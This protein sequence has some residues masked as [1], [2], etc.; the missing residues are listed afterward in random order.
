MSIT[1]RDFL[2]GILAASMA[3][4]IVRAESLM[5]L[6]VPN[7]KII[8]YADDFVSTPG[9]AKYGSSDYLK[10]DETM[11][12]GFGDGDFTVETWIR[13]TDVNEWKHVAQVQQNSKLLSYIDG[14][15]VPNSEFTANGFKITKSDARFTIGFDK[16][17][18]LGHVDPY[19]S[20]QI[21]DLR[22]TQGVAR[23]PELLNAAAH[24]VQNSNRFTAD[25]LCEFGKSAEREVAKFEIN[26]RRGIQKMESF[27]DRAEA[28][29]KQETP[30][31]LL[32]SLLGRS[33]V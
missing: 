26:A 11:F 4:A 32:A 16:A 7:E 20:G 10:A 15:L 19:F 5:K 25:Y 3:P 21:D 28:I 9:L 12:N 17:P 6:Y 30:S 8:G 33:R 31:G 18:N 24:R 23:T 29:A 1:R 27:V 22:I 2:K 13:P 14:K